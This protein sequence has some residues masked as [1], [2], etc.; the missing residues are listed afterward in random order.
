[1]LNEKI[2]FIIAQ[3]G[4]EEIQIKEGEKFNPETME[5]LATVPVSE[6]D[7]DGTVILID[8]KG[9]KHI[10]S[11]LVFKTAKVIIGKFNS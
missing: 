7:K 2:I 4:F 3:N 9:Y 1:M 6:K 11:G 8:Q 5:A 10:E